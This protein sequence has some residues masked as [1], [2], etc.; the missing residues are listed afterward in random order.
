VVR[1][2]EVEVWTIGAAIGVD[3]EECEIS[4]NEYDEGST[5]V[6]PQFLL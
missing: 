5:D 3:E 4:G 6:T 1:P 2:K